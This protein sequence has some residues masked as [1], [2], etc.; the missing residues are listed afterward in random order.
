MVFLACNCSCLNALF[1]D[2]CWS[3][4]QSF[5]YC[6]SHLLIQMGLLKF[7]F[8]SCTIHLLLHPKLQPPV[9][10]VLK[11]LVLLSFDTLCPLG[12]V[13]KGSPS[14][15]TFIFLHLFILLYIFFSF[16]RISH[17]SFF[18]SFVYLFLI[19]CKESVF[20]KRKK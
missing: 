8:K 13:A 3:I 18:C 19:K 6:F 17:P 20:I 4:S 2:H 9:D 10:F 5:R 16:W 15:G 1:Q 7:C 12:W 11:T 14:V